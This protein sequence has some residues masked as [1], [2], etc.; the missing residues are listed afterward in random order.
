MES[1]SIPETDRLFLHDSYLFT[2]TAT[3]R[4][5][6]SVEE[7]EDVIIYLDRTIFHP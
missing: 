3:I 1:E 7:S 2:E 5:V 6:R 4:V